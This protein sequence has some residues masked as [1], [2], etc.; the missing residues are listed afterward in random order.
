[1][2]VVLELYLEED[3]MLDIQKK[4]AELGKNISILYVEDEVQTREQYTEIFKLLFKNVT[5][6]GDGELALEEYKDRRY[7]LLI[8]D[9]TMPNM[10]GVSLIT[11][12]FKIDPHQH[13]IIMTAHNTS[14]NLRSSIDF[15]VDG[16]LLKPIVLDK[17]LSLLYKVCHLIDLEKNDKKSISYDRMFNNK[18][19]SLFL[20]VIDKFDEIINQFG[21]KI[22]DPIIQAVKEHLSYFGIEEI[23][24]VQFQDDVLIC[25][26]DKNYLE[27]ILSSLENFSDTNHTLIVSLNKVKIY[28]TLSY[29]VIIFKED[30]EH[31]E[32]D[33][34]EHINNVVLEIKNDDYS[35]FVVKMDVSPEE[36]NKNNSLNWLGVTLDALKQ[37]SIVPFY[38]PIVE[39]ENMQV[40]S[41]EVFA[42]IKQENRYI[43]PKFFIDLSKKAGILEDIS[44]SIFKKSFY[45]FSQTDFC[46]H[47]NL[48]DLDLRTNAMKDYLVYLSSLYNIEH[49]RVIL[50]IMNHEKLQHLGKTV[51][52]L[53][54][55]KELGFQLALKG[56]GTGSIN[57]ELVSKLLPHYIKIDANILQKS[58]SDA[59]IR[60][61]VAFL[62]NYTKQ[63]AIKSIVVGVESQ[64]IVEIAKELGIEYIQGYL[65]QKPSSSL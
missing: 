21:N 31:S 57:I 65:I 51:K 48:S 41:Y 54:E 45:D 15:Q 17:F 6:V 14:D 20:V 29:G 32:E 36:I 27:Q 5:S 58:L 50:N 25:G 44:K 53:L 4:L 55:L 64:A 61:M 42:R 63:V 26:A 30:E 49:N 60:A 62:I 12:V 24:I 59:N 18:E 28:I 7:D 23:N 39:I 13:T 1:M 10:D 40:S 46:F 34:F 47:I 2:V 11:E 16:I 22:K 19:E 8:T 37:E 35:N 56:F 38:Q 33:I 9:L 52:V 3:E 43:L